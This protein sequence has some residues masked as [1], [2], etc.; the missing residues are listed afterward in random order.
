MSFARLI[1]VLILSYCSIG[2]SF[3]ETRSLTNNGTD[4]PPLAIYQQALNY[5]LGRNGSEKS[6]EKAAELFKTLAEQNWS[7]AQHMLGN[8]YFSGNGVEKNDL[9]AYKW[10]SI[11]SRNNIRLAETI[12]EKRKILQNRLTKNNLQQV[13]HWIAEWRP[14]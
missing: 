6:A 9:L 14:D 12:Y 4:Q 11:A 2:F 13:D 5:L 1:T 7:S 3:A 8:M 10:L